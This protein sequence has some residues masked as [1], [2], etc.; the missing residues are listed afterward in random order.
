MTWFLG[1][2]ILYYHNFINEETKYQ[3]GEVHNG[4]ILQRALPGLDTCFLIQIPFFSIL[5]LFLFFMSSSPA[6][7][8]S[9]P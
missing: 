8:H 4:L 3:S 7:K 5:L 9:S 1:S 2:L 6:L